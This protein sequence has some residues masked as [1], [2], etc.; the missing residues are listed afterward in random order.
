MQGV[1]VRLKAGRGMCR[2][3]RVLDTLVF[4]WVV[5]AWWAGTGCTWQ[6]F[7][8]RAAA[9]P[10]HHP[11]VPSPAPCAC[12]CFSSL[13]HFR[14]LPALPV[15][16]PLWSPSSSC[17]CRRTGGFVPSSKGSYVCRLQARPPPELVSDSPCCC[18]TWTRCRSLLPRSASRCWTWWRP[19]AT[20]RPKTGSPADRAWIW[21]TRTPRPASRAVKAW[22]GWVL[23]MLDWLTS[24][25]IMDL[26]D[27]EA[28]AAHN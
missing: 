25:V 9:C 27:E 6:L 12:P 16:A 20:A 19:R 26:E 8:G 21:K 17:C 1:E 4:A 24:E 15:L 5:D 18:R 10:G 13:L 28:K 3:C 22:K 11:G 23:P 7:E 14:H 2:R